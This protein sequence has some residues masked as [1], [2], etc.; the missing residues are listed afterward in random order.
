MPNGHFR[1]R[2]EKFGIVEK[3][4]VEAENEVYDPRPANPPGGAAA[5]LL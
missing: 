5:G 2:G 3:E 4:M 1:K